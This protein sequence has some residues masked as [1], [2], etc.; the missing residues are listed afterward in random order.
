M[1]QRGYTMLSRVR[2][3]GL[4]LAALW[5][6]LWIA[7]ERGHL[8]LPSTRR[9]LDEM[10]GWRYLFSR[11]F[12]HAYIYGRWSNQ[13]IGWSIRHYFPFVHPRPGNPMWAPDYHGKV[14]PTALAESLISVKQPVCR[15]NLE[16]IIP[17][18]TA[19]D[20]VLSGPPDIAVYDCPC[21]S[22][23]ENPCQPTDVCMIVGQPFVDFIVEHNPG[24]ARRLSTEEAIQLLRDEHDRGHIHAAYFKD[25]MFE[26]FY[27]ICN[28]CSCCCGGI[29]AMRRGVPMVIP[30][31]F[32]AEVDEALCHGCGTCETRCPFD[33]IAVNGHAAVD[34]ERCMGC[35]VCID[36]C[37]EEAL[38]L[39]RDA[40]KGEPLDV[41]ALLEG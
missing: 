11:R 10:G 18:P 35:G 17:F 31:G 39:V 37:P 23:R 26:R 40:R 12:W 6:A 36:H 7:G 5:A 1:P 32:V 33:A 38:A 29:D 27:A 34:W 3:V 15:E 25:V 2:K 8:M 20:L 14:L 13:Y 21:R 22:A 19:R 41:Q 30:S 9:W 16:Q 24:S 28:C 4:L